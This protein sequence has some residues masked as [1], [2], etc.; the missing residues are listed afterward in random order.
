[1][2]TTVGIFKSQ[3][4]TESALAQ[5]K[6]SG[7]GT[8][9]LPV[10][11]PGTTNRQVEVSV[12]TGDSEG[13]GMRAAMGGTV[14]GAIGAGVGASLG[15]AVVSLFIPG[16]GPIIAAGILGAALLGTGGA[17]AGVQAGGL[18]EGDWPRV[19]RTTN[20]LFTKMPSRHGHMRGDCPCRR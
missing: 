16:V 5:L 14:G 1:M 17:L 6:G 9:K 20:F 15:A 13:S 7:L 3:A 12:Q 10:L 18:L 19:C 11:R 2:E 8:T 4:G